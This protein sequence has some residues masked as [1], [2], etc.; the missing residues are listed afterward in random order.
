M[1]D[2]E[3]EAGSGEID[4]KM[5]AEVGE[6]REGGVAILGL[7]R[8]GVRLLQVLQRQAQ[9]LLRARLVAHVVVALAEL[10]MPAS[11]R[12]VA[13]TAALGQREHAQEEERRV[14]VLVRTHRQLGSR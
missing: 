11:E 1:E 13:L 3:S 7:G 9:M 5:G 4:L 10:S 6:Q 8:L 2:K 14:P 12:Q